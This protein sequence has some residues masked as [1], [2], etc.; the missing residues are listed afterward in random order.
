[1]HVYLCCMLRLPPEVLHCVECVHGAKSLSP[2]GL[3]L[4]ALRVV[5]PQRPFILQG[6]FPGEVWLAAALL[7]MC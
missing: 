1:M 6:M 2:G 5:K 3:A 7:Q 4:A